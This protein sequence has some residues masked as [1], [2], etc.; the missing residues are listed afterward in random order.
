M[1]E[2]E[3]WIILEGLD[4]RWKYGNR[5]STYENSDSGRKDN[6]NRAWKGHEKCLQEVAKGAV[7]VC[8]LP[9]TL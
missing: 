3:Q 7:V 1:K 5:T 6:T 2:S 4:G 8:L 9:A